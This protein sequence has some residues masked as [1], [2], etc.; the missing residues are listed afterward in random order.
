MWCVAQGNADAIGL[1]WLSLCD[2]CSA[3][4]HMVSFRARLDFSSIFYVVL[5]WHRLAEEQKDCRGTKV[6]KLIYLF[7]HPLAGKCKIETSPRK[8][9]SVGS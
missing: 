7:G 4:S 1:L 8:T 2:V 3:I 9:V 6:E 5:C